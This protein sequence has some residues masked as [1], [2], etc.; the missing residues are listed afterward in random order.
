MYPLLGGYIAHAVDNEWRVGE[1]LQSFR[2][3][4]NSY[5]TAFFGIGAPHAKASTVII[6]FDLRSR[7][8]VDVS[9]VTSRKCAYLAKETQL[10][11]G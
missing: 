9:E 6:F 2:V 10:E 8:N 11:L 4:D 3:K 1:G 7:K 5:T